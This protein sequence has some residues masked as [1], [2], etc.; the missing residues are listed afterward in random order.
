MSTK[1]NCSQ[2]TCELGGEAL[3]S[4]GEDILV[5]VPLPGV[6]YLAHVQVVGVVGPAVPGQLLD[7]VCLEVN[8]FV[9]V[10][11]SFVPPD[12]LLPV[13]LHGGLVREL[14]LPLDVLDNPESADIEHGVGVVL[15]LDP[16]VQQLVVAS[17]LP[18]QTFVE[19]RR[20]EDIAGLQPQVLSEF[21]LF[22]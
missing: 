14:H 17:L 8:L 16:A 15:V 20:V 18:D 7:K 6:E 13:R 19:A 4:V 9:A 2:L 10:G 5:L 22:S 12:P 11:E 21:M 3:V 1:V